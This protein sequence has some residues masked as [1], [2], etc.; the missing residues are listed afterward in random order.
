[1]EAQAALMVT[2][3]F[4]L[5]LTVN[6]PPLTVLPM[7]KNVP[8]RV[9]RHALATAV[10]RKA[11]ARASLGLLE[12]LARCGTQRRPPPPTLLL[13]QTSAPASMLSRAP[14]TDTATLAAA[15]AM[16]HLMAKHVNMKA[17]LTPPMATVTVPAPP[18]CHAPARAH[19]CT[20]NAD[21]SA[22]FKAR[23]VTS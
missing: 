16:G 7:I 17:P 22:S 10:A 4:K 12:T 18:V 14:A 6:P 13:A 5:A 11:A 3:R 20:V 9:A 15:S 1:M 19:V 2:R 8:A 21:V 23:P